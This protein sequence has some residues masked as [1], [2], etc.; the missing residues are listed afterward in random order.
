VNEEINKQS[1]SSFS[2]CFSPLLKA[3]AFSFQPLPRPSNLVA[4]GTKSQ[5]LGAGS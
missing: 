2:E 3:G 1:E 4:P 5:E